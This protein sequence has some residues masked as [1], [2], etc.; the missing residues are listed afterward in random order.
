MEPYFTCFGCLSSFSNH[1]DLLQHLKVLHPFVQKYECKQTDCNRNFPNLNGL[2]K[3]LLKM[4]PLNMYTE[5]KANIITHKEVIDDS[6]QVNVPHDSNSD[7]NESVD[8]EGESGSPEYVCR[9][10]ILRVFSKYYGNSALPRNFVQIVLEDMGELLCSIFCSIKALIKPFSVNLKLQEVLDIF[11]TEIET[12]MESFGEHLRFKYLEKSN[13]FIKP[14]S[15]AVGE[16]N[17]LVKSKIS[18][19]TTMAVVKS[20]CQFIPLRKTLKQYLELPNVFDSICS[21]IE[22]EESL[23][24]G[25]NTTIITS[26]YQGMLWQDLKTKFSKKIVIFIF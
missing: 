20:D 6:D 2:R 12:T 11:F 3:H 25:S 1:Q 9:N 17:E 16:R 10:A 26:L 21:Y 22:T 15:Y 24:K 4:H 7:G 14:E 8:N 19:G 5:K 13:F 23:N 18:P